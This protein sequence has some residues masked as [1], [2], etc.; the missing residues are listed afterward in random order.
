MGESAINKRFRTARAAAT[1]EL[2]KKNYTVWP[3][4]GGPFDLIAFKRKEVRLIRIC[5]DEIKEEVARLTLGAV[6][7]S[8]VS[9]ECWR[10]WKNEKEFRIFKEDGEFPRF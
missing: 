5:L 10:R 8:D 7:D 9:R 6:R 3:L 4:N 2:I 1:L